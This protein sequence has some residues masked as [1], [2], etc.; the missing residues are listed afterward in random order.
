MF[1]GTGNLVITEEGL[2]ALNRSLGSLVTETGAR[3]ALLMDR[4]GQLLAAQGETSGLD[5]MSLGALLVG[6]FG[7]NRAIATIFGEAEFKLLYQ[8][9][10]QQSLMIQPVGAQALI[11]VI[12]SSQIPLGKVKLQ[13]EQL[14]HPLETQVAA[15]LEAGVPLPRSQPPPP[16]LKDLF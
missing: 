7:S 15:M 14:R 9:G 16:T 2:R 8:Q 6:T 1:K 3:A 12:F 10:Q 4:S 11:A 5:T 13:M